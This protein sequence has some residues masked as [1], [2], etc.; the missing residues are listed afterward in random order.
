MIYYGFF[1]KGEGAGVHVRCG[2]MVLKAY[3]AAFTFFKKHV[4]LRHISGTNHM[5]RSLF[6]LK[7]TCASGK[8]G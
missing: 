2:L 6:A 5:C 3:A 7:N 1:K 8:G 4:C